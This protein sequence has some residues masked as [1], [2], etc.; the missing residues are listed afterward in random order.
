LHIHSS[1][2][3]K[4]AKLVHP[5]DAG[6]E[7]DSLTQAGSKLKDMSSFDKASQKFLEEMKATFSRLEKE[8]KVRMK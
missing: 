6:T 8:A 5:V 2:A 7:D 3:S 4:P 1:R